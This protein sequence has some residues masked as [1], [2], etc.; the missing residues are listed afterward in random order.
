MAGDFASGQWKV[1]ALKKIMGDPATRFPK[2]QYTTE[3]QNKVDLSSTKDLWNL[4]FDQRQK[5]A[6][7]NAQRAFKYRGDESV[8]DF[9]QKK[10]FSAQ[11]FN[12]DRTIRN[13]ELTSISNREAAQAQAR[14]RLAGVQQQLQQKQQESER[15]AAI[16]AFRGRF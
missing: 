15:G 13:D 4:G 10:D 1:D 16:S 11:E 5:E 6:E 2:A 3:A 9:G 8:R 12:Q 14:E 7:A